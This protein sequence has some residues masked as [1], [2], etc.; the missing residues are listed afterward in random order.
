MSETK[1]VQ[2]QQVNLKGS[3][4]DKIFLTNIRRVSSFGYLLRDYLFLLYI[5][6]NKFGYMISQSWNKLEAKKRG[7]KGGLPKV[8][9]H[10]LS[11]EMRFLTMKEETKHVSFHCL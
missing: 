3:L 9:A 1:S 2:N 11:G 5:Q 8:D 4:A 7:I 10:I 6:L